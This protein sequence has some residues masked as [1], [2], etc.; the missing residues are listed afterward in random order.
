MPIPYLLPL[1]FAILATPPIEGDL[2]LLDL[3]K[4]AQRGK[5][6]LYPHGEFFVLIEH[7]AVGAKRPLL[8][9]EGL[10]RWDGEK[11][12]FSGL[13]RGFKPPPGVIDEN[14]LH[15]FP[16]DQIID[17]HM[18]AGYVSSTNL[19][20]VDPYPQVGGGPLFPQ[21]PDQEWFRFGPRPIIEVLGPHP[22]F[23][24]DKVKSFKIERSGDDLV[25]LTR[26]DVDGFECRVVASLKADGNIVEISGKQKSGAWDI[27]KYRW[28]RDEKGRLYLAELY[29]EARN[30]EPTITKRWHRTATRAMAYSH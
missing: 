10:F 9:T 6:G 11:A 7:G 12:R 28:K 3:M 21:R 29:K 18:N 19:V 13:Q 25:S 26:F 30:Y 14:Y 24:L 8:Q 27:D 4:D 23:P 22:N 15:E 16:I 1:V 17:D 5:E 20:R 2:K